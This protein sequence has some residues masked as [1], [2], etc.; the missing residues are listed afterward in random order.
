M[1]RRGKRI[2]TWGCRSGFGVATFHVGSEC[3]ERRWG[4][5]PACSGVLRKCA[6]SRDSIEGWRRPIRARQFGCKLHFIRPVWAQTRGPS[7][8]Y[9]E[10]GWTRMSGTMMAIPPYTMRFFLLCFGRV[11]KQL[12]HCLE[13]GRIRT[14]ETIMARRRCIAR[15]LWEIVL[16]LSQSSRHCFWLMRNQT[17]GIMAAVLLYMMQQATVTP[18]LLR[19]CWRLPRIAM[20]GTIRAMRRP[21]T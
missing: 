14:R 12:M 13:E 21:Y 11:L 4:N 10:P 16:S 19:S 8:H 5:R 17:P 1:R 2:S 20:L 7:K 3:T 9:F 18:E 6:I 15:H